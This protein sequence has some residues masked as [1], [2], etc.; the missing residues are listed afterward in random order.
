MFQ[1]NLSHKLL[2]VDNDIIYKIIASINNDPVKS[3]SKG[4]TLLILGNNVHSSC[5]TIQ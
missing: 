2:T 1:Y 5:I 3:I 4:K